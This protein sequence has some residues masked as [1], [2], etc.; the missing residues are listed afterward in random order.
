MPG[1]HEVSEAAGGMPSLEDRLRALA[2]AGAGRER[3][4]R[5]CRTP[6]GPSTIAEVPVIQ[7]AWI[8]DV[9][10][11]RRGV[12]LVTRLLPPEGE[13]PAEVQQ[14]ADDH[15][16]GDRGEHRDVGLLAGRLLDARPAGRCGPRTSATSRQPMMLSTIQRTSSQTTVSPAHAFEPTGA[17]AAASAAIRPAPP[18][19][20]SCNPA[21]PSARRCRRRNPPP[22]GTKH[23]QR[24]VPAVFGVLKLNVT[25][26][27]GA[28]RLVVVVS[29]ARRRG[30]QGVVLV[31]RRRR[32]DRHVEPEAGDRERVLHRAVRPRVERRHRRRPARTSCR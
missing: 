9:A 27:C 22:Q 1:D 24:K 12:G 32:R 10:V 25:T 5:R 13:R 14:H 7:V 6:R 18:S 21:W 16:R 23:C 30:A 3:S 28:L 26:E 11:D 29:H 4:A 31:H 15:R 20:P 19:D 17:L 2:G 8:L